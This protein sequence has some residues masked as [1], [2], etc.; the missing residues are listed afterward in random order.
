MRR[1]ILPENSEWLKLEKCYE[2][3]DTNKEQRSYAI[4]RSKSISRLYM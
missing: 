1:E 2:L 3:H 4:A